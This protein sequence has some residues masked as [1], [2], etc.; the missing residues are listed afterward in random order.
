MPNFSDL[1]PLLPK[2]LSL[3]D[4]S[5]SSAN[6]NPDFDETVFVA[7]SDVLQEILSSSAL[8]DGAGSKTLTEPLLLW[9][10]T[11]GGQI[12]QGTLDGECFSLYL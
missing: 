11:W 9:L 12:V 6:G 3:L 2:L 8:S 10:E 7:A 4:P 5:N 1:T